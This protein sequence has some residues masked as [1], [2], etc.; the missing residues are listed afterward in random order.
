METMKLGLL[1]SNDSNYNQIKDLINHTNGCEEQF[2][3][4]SPN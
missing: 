3:A 2:V 1:L 4:H